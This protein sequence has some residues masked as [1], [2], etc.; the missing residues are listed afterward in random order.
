MWPQTNPLTV[1]CAHFTSLLGKCWFSIFSF[2]TS[3]KYLISKVSWCLSYFTPFIHYTLLCRI[4][5]SRF[6]W[7]LPSTVQHHALPVLQPWRHLLLCQQKWQVLLVVNHRSSPYD[8]CRRR[9]HQ[10][11]HKSLLSVWS[12]VGCHCDPQPGHHHPT[13]SRRLAQPVD[14]LLLPHGEFQ[15]HVEIRSEGL[16]ARLKPALVLVVIYLDQFWR[17]EK[18]Y[19]YEGKLVLLW[20]LWKRFYYVSGCSGGALWN[21]KTALFNTKDSPQPPLLQTGD[22]NVS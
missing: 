9:R 12:S 17:Q 16:C 22:V 3:L 18:I 5:F 7:L 8:A 10:T 14:W 13:V 6:S 1:S 20:S 4:V 15:F 2:K 19:T 11:V 21:L